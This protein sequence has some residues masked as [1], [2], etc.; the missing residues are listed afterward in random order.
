PDATVSHVEIVHYQIFCP[1]TGTATFVVVPSGASLDSAWEQLHAVRDVFVSAF[2]I[3]DPAD[4]ETTSLA[5]VVLPIQLPSD[6]L[7]SPL[8]APVPL[9]LVALRFAQ[10]LGRTML[11]F[12]DDRRRA[13][14]FRQIFGSPDPLQAVGAP[15]A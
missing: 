6:E 1:R 12:D 3:C 4:T 8:V 2:A 11:G 14:N 5:D 10:R 15:H 13:I 9:E 7:L